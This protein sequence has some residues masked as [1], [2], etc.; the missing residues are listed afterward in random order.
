MRFIRR[1]AFLV[2]VLA[3]ATAV[4]Q[5]QQALSNV[6]EFS[7]LRWHVAWVLGIWIFLSFVAGGLVF[8]FLDAWRILRYQWKLR[9]RDQQIAKLQQELEATH[10]ARN[11]T[12]DLPPE[13]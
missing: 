3:L 7:F 11:P 8:L 1:I 2:L 5:N 13:A 12:S 10:S 4:F 9:G 6:V